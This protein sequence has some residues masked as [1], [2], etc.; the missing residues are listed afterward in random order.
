MLYNVS[1]SLVFKRSIN[2][3]YIL[4]K[5][6]IKHY[7]L[8]PCPHLT[9]YSLCSPQKWCFLILG[10]ATAICRNCYNKNKRFCD[11]GEWAACTWI[12]ILQCRV[13]NFLQVGFLVLLQHVKLFHEGT[14]GPNLLPPIPGILNSCSFLVTSTFFDCTCIEHSGIITL[15]SHFPP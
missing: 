11:I 8:H 2:Y 14:G 10:L 6:F 1:R 12:S 13:N 5:Y 7:K 4:H 3:Y 9:G 15:F